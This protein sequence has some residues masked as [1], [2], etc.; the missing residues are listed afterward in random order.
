MVKI[1]G[2]SL[3]VILMKTAL[4]RQ[5]AGNR[6]GLED[7]NIPGRACSRDPNPLDVSRVFH[8]RLS[9]HNDYLVPEIIWLHV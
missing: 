7:Q 8:A 6:P 9:P 4:V 5:N 2:V 3:F 1:H